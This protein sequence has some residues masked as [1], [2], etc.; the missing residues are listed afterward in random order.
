VSGTSQVQF[1]FSAPLPST[2]LFLLLL[3]VRAKPAPLRPL[4]VTSIN[5]WVE[6]YR[7]NKNFRKK[8]TF[9]YRLAD[10]C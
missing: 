6:I 8:S 7:E 3:V 2:T 1:N 4:L 5:F 9:K 10:A